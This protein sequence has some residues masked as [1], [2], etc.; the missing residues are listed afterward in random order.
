M[1]SRILEVH[2]SALRSRTISKVTY[3]VQVPEPD[4]L[5]TVFNV[6]TKVCAEI[7]LTKLAP[8]TSSLRGKLKLDL[9]RGHSQSGHYTHL[10]DRNHWK[11][12]SSHSLLRLLGTAFHK[13]SLDDDG[14]VQFASFSRWS[15]C[16]GRLYKHIASPESSHE[17]IDADI[18]RSVVNGAT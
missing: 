10:R 11:A 3:C 7:L 16:L 9:A 12:P 14:Q 5:V 2:D 18:E 4:T 6:E 1:I 17:S 8:K 15:R 13:E